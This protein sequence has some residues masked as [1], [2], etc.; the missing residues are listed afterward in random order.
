MIL[1]FRIGTDGR[2][3]TASI[4]FQHAPDQADVFG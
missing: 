3:A 4:S 2:F 1:H